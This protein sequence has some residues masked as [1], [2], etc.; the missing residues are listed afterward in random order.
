MA[1]GATLDADTPDQGVKIARRNTPFPPRPLHD[2]TDEEPEK[3]L[4][5]LADLGPRGLSKK[6]PPSNSEDERQLRSVAGQKLPVRAAAKALGVSPS[7]YLRLVRAQ[8][9]SLSAAWSAHH[10]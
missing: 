10:A 6:T 5:P 2:L 9:A 7:S 3:A 8:T 1:G 4:L